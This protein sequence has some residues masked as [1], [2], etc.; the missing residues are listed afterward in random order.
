M[1]GPPAGA[2]ND[3]STPAAP[4]VEQEEWKRL[5]CDEPAQAES[6]VSGRFT[7]GRDAPRTRLILSANLRD[8]CTIRHEDGEPQSLA[9]DYA[10]IAAVC[11]DPVTDRAQVVIHAG[12]GSACCPIEIW[13]VEAQDSTPTRLHGEPWGDSASWAEGRWS[14]RH[15]IAEDGTCL[16]R[17]RRDA[18]ERVRTALAVLGVGESAPFGEP[19]VPLPT[20][21]IAA[22]TVRESLLELKGFATLERPLYADHAD[23]D[24]WRVVQFTGTS[25]YYAGEEVT[26][27]GVV[28]VQDRQSGT[29]RAI[30]DVPGRSAKRSD[31]R[32]LAMM[33][34][35]DRLL[36]GM[37]YSD[38]GHWGDYRRFAIDLRT[39]RATL[40]ETATDTEDE[41]RPVA[42][43]G[44]EIFADAPYPY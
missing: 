30:Y 21:E 28:L 12:G 25:S 4:A 19:I 14:L 36:A 16:W 7:G 31:F 29:W 27:G 20:R 13:S 8:G 40:L 2:G 11:F 43:L 23:W 10:R 35:D 18:D 9:V 15:L 1:S 38:C 26:N 39:P 37:C 5:F 44:A 33:V 24:S 3:T 32:L 41:N 34:D 17:E 6:V 42:D 22:A